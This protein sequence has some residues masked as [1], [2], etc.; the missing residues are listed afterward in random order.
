MERPIYPNA[1]ILIHPETTAAA[2]TQIA[3]DV[4]MDLVHN[5]QTGNYRLEQKRADA[6]AYLRSRGK[7]ILDRGTPTPAWGHGPKDAA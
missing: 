5:P 2:A 1:L 7:Y 4:D 3:R 6:I